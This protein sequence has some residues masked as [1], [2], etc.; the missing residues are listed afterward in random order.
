MISGLPGIYTA[1][2]SV[3][4]WQIAE[5]AQDLGMERVVVEQSAAFARSYLHQQ[6]RARP[7]VALLEVFLARYGHHCAYEEEWLHPRWAEE[8]EQVIAMV[9]SYLRAV[10]H[11]DPL[12][13]L[14]ERRRQHH[15]ALEAVEAHLGFIRHR[16]FRRLL[17]KV[18]HAVLLRDNSKHYLMKLALPACCIY[19]ML[20]RRWVIRGWLSAHA[21]LFFLTI[22]EIETVSRAGSPGAAGLDL[23][24]LIAE[25]RKAYHHWFGVEAPQVAGADG[26]PHTLE[27]DRRWRRH[28]P[29]GPAGQWC[30]VRG[31][32]R[33][34][35][36]AQE[37]G[38]IQPGDILVARSVDPGWTPL[39]PLIGG[40][41]LEIGGQL[42]HA[43]LVAREY[44]IP[45]I[46]NVAEAMQRIHEGPGDHP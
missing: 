16:L 34:V 40:L 12:E 38:R 20:G 15:V 9:A 13:A 35:H 45:A 4:L 43:I 37:V 22:P 11:I 17:A 24:A 25:R 29:G 31:V 8:P 2:M 28:D 36:T 44:G 32:A 6:P 5:Q 23:P 42:S 1:E 19:R 14:A 18:Q 30:C 41:V 7:V 3:S 26:R 46:V 27:R 21:D 39:F 10:D 33:I